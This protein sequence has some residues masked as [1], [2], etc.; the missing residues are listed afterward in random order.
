MH[1]AERTSVTAQFARRI[2][3]IAILPDL[4]PRLLSLLPPLRVSTKV[5]NFVYI[6]ATSLPHLFSYQL[7]ATKFSMET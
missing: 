1:I 3:V 5:L 6:R 2:H 7:I 4:V